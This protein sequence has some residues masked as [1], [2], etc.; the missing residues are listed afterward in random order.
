M[1]AIDMT[2]EVIQGVAWALSTAMGLY[3][4]IRVIKLFQGK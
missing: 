1:P 3:F 4:V 2:L